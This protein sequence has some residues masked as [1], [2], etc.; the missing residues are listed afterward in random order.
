[1]KKYIVLLLFGI[2]FLILAC[3]N[4]KQE[5]YMKALDMI[6]KKEWN[7]VLNQLKNL[8]GYEDANVLE[9]FVL[10]NIAYNNQDSFENNE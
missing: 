7:Q 10:A 3:A 4:T 6:E 2:V 8:S 1:M 5:N 9:I